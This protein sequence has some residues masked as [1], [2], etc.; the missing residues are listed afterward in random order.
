MPIRPW[1][2]GDLAIR[3]ND[4]RETVRPYREAM[5]LVGRRLA[6]LVGPVEESG[7]VVPLNDPGQPE[8]FDIAG[9]NPSMSGEEQEAVYEKLNLEEL[10]EL[11]RRRELPVSGN[12][13]DLIERLLEADA[14]QAD[15]DDDLIGLSTDADASGAS[16]ED[17]PR[18]EDSSDDGDD[19]S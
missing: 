7:D 8:T 5:S 15:D 1:G 16:A 4:G 6:E 18:A 11:L 14:A 9:P 3:M 13:P 10:R 17:E 19:E 12:K 2:Q